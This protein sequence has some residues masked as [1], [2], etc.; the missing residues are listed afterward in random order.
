MPGGYLPLS[1]ACELRAPADTMVYSTEQG[2]AG[3]SAVHTL[4]AMPC[5]VKDLP[6]LKGLMLSG[7][8][9]GGVLRTQCHVL[10]SSLPG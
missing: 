9:A 5:S 10:Q 1:H 7:T 8:P 3:I 4:T 2:Q 6:Q